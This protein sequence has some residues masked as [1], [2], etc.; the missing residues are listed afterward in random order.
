MAKAREIVFFAY[1]QC[2][3][4]DV[5]GPASVFGVANSIAGRKAYE[6]KITSPG[7]R[8]IR[9]SCGVELATTRQDL[10]LGRPV[11]TVL[12]SGGS[13]EA[14]R[15]SIESAGTRRSLKRATKLANRFGSVCS[16]VFV[17]AALEALG[18]IR[19]ATHWASCGSLVRMYPHLTVDSKALFVV[20]GRAWTS[21]GVSTGIDMALAMVERD[22][23]AAVANRVAKFLV[24]YARRPGYQS[25]FSEILTAQSAADSQFADVVAWVHE[26]LP[27]KIEVSDLAARA[28]LTERTFYRRFSA[29]TGQTPAQFI[30]SAR[31]DVAR[32]LLEGD[33]PLKAIVKRCGLGS[34]T[35]LNAAFLRKFGMSPTTFRNLHRRKPAFANR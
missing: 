31:L 33:L 2:Q 8:S 29:A 21:A 15:K 1:D 23:G 35:W 24:L 32:T 7:G 12:I 34:I 26:H 27:R 22:L 18:P 16:G 6:V 28:S 19:V 13:L 14:M 11:D 20:D 3:L 4:L 25:Q 9:T 10:A 5:A 17:L 30:R